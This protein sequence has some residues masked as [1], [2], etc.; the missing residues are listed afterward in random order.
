MDIGGLAAI[1][2]S[3]IWDRV[4]QAIGEIRALIIGFGLQVI[5][6]IIP[7]LTDATIPNVLAAGL[8]GITVTGI[9][10][11]MLSLVGRRFPANSSSAMARLTTS[12]GV[13]QIIAPA[14][15]GMLASMTGGYRISLW[16]AA[17]MMTIG[18]ISLLRLLKHESL[19][20]N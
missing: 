5:S 6:I 2:A 19:S 11:L 9:V 12:Y 8:F 17:A 14:I 16:M 20:V 10:S 18:M 7:A 13:A 4:A 3:F 1:P 15:A